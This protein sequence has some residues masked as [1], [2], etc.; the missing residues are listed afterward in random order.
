LRVTIGTPVENTE[1]LTALADVL[2]PTSTGEEMRA[3]T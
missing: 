1:F 3:T 2:A